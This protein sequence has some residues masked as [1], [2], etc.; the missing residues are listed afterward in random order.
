MKVIKLRECNICPTF[1][2][3]KWRK[4]AVIMLRVSFSNALYS[5]TINICPQCLTNMRSLPK[6]KKM[7][8]KVIGI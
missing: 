1:K 5:T 8:G 7:L 3:S 2:R 6:N 4:K